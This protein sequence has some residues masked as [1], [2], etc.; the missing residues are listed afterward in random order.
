MDY[1]NPEIPEGANISK[2]H[3]LKEFFL[4]T[5]AVISIVFI[6]VFVISLMAEKLAIYIPFSVEQELTGEF[7]EEE[8]DREIQNYLQTMADDLGSHMDLPEGMDITLHYVDEDVKNAFATLGGHVYIYRG[9]LEVIP[10]ENA[11]AMVVAHEIAHIKH[12]HPII[13]MGRGVVIGLL[14]AALSGLSSDMFVGEVVT[15]TGMIA[16]MNFTRDQ[17]RQS[18]DTALY[19]LTQY[20][21]HV[22]GADDLFRSFLQMENEQLITVPQFLSTHPLSEERIENIRNITIE[23]G[24]VTEQVIT[25]LPDFL[26]R[27]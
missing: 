21:G 10:H 5:G 2:T 25:P 14:F 16:M 6:T 11:L 17:E 9:L 13:A 4:L 26:K 8:T 1:S 18:D 7:I 24:W 23:N 12:R 19:A 20:Y 27:D 15:S 3:P 22:S